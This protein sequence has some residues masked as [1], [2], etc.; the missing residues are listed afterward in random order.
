MKFEYD[1]K[2][3]NVECVAYVDK[4]NHLVVKNSRSCESEDT[5]FVFMTTSSKDTTTMWDEF[6]PDNAVKKFYPGD[7]I[8]ITF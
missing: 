6:N 3:Y 5:S 1:S 8:T 4:H 2:S 7:K